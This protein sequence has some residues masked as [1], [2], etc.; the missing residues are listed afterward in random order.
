[1][2]LAEHR[3]DEAAKSYQSALQL[4]PDDVEAAKALSAVRAA[5]EERARTKKD[6]EKRQS[7]FTRLMDQ[8]KEALKGQQFVAA[9]RAF[10]DALRLIPDNAA[11]A[12]AFHEASD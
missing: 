7:E 9:A 12:K 10:D 11:A 3:F 2:A 6:E 1:T 5:L 8:G 4:F